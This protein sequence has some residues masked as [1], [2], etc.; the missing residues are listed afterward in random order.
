VIGVYALFAAGS[1]L[2][3]SSSMSIVPQ[4]VSAELLPDAIRVS[5]SLLAIGRV[6]G[7]ALAGLLVSWVGVGAAFAV[8]A[9]SFGIAVVATAAIRASTVGTSSAAAGDAAMNPAAAFVRQLRG[10]FRVIY[11][12]P[13]LLSLC[14]AVAFFNLVLSPMQVLLPTY[15]KLAKGMPAWFLGGLESSLGLGIVVGAVG[16]GA[17]EKIPR[18]VSSVVVG[19]VLLGGAI[20]LLP[21]VP[22]VVPPMLLMFAMGL[23]V[24]WTEIPIGARI[25]VAVPDHFRSRVTSIFA[26]VFNGMAPLGIAVG[27]ALVAVLGVTQTMT[28]LG[29]AV[30]LAVPV[31]FAVPGL[32]AFFR[33]SPPE[34]ADYFREAH[35]KAF[36][37]E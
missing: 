2:F 33:R 25:S 21:H 22:G 13:V 6:L 32:V 28:G 34:L 7:G 16:I 18:L 27:G 29:A 8:D 17:L 35:P 11:R 26:F 4:L 15:V 24:A 20:A 5:Q 3:N 37:N 30:L 19:L 10:G 12:V 9:V 36:L 31:L 14:V 23:G 1:A